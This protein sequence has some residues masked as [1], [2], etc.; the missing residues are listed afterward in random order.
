MEMV[1]EIGAEATTEPK[2]ETKTGTA[3][4][5][6]VRAEGEPWV[7]IARGVDLKVLRASAET[8]AWTTLVRFT[9]K[10]V[11]PR[12]WHLSASEFYVLEG[13]GN[14]PQAGD[15]QPGDYFYEH[16]GAFHD[17][18]TTEEEVILYMVSHGPSAFIAADDSVSYVM[19]AGSIEA[20]VRREGRLGALFIAKAAV[21]SALSRLF[22]LP[23]F[24][25]PVREAATRLQAGALPWRRLCDGVDAKALHTGAERGNWTAL[26]RLRPGSSVPRRRLLSAADLFVIKGRGNHAQAGAFADHDY[27]FENAGGICGELTADEEVL[28]LMVSHG[29]AAFVDADG[30]VRQILDAGALTRM[31]ET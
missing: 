18:V 12:H 27:V 3:S 11:L 6:R 19:D 10:G 22:P 17:E 7:P 1:M 8:G 25:E 31:S 16:N 29:P 21:R 28:L 2:S 5:T 13:A 24:A 30:S 20:M 23:Q 26:L 15:F 9:P 4:A 14:H